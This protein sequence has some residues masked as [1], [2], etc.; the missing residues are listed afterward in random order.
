MLDIRLSDLNLVKTDKIMNDIYNSEVVD[1]SNCNMID[2]PDVFS[3]NLNSTPKKIFDL[4][5][6]LKNHFYLIAG[7]SNFH[8]IDISNLIRLKNK[9]KEKIQLILFDSH[10]D[11]I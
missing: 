9:L 2:D 7:S 11:A 1:L 4:S 6:K 8:H 10:M 5:L 3:L